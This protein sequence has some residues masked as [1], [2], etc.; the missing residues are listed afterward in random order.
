MSYAL[1][2]PHRIRWGFSAGASTAM[3]ALLVAAAAVLPATGLQHANTAPT[4]AAATEGGISPALTKLADRHP[5]KRIEAIVQ[6]RK[7]VGPAEARRVSRAHD[8]RVIGD[9]HVING[10]ALRMSAGDA[11]S[12]AKDERVRAISLN[13]RV[14]ENG[15]GR[16]QRRSLDAGVLSSLLATSYNRSIQATDAWAA[17]GTGD[18]IGVAVVDTGIAAGHADFLTAPRSSSRVV[19]S[20][21][22]NPYAKNDGDRYGHGTH[23]AGIA[24]GNSLNRSA[25]DPHYGEY[26]GTAPEADLINVKIADE[27][28]NATV[29][30]AIYG[31]QFVID[32]KADYNIRV[33]NL[34]FESAAADSYKIDPL[35]AAAEAAWFSGIVVVAA[36]G[37]RGTASDAVHHAPGNDPY[38]I[39]VGASDDKGTATIGDDVVASWSSRGKT[40]DGFAKPD[41]V[42]PGTRIVSTLAQN[43]E[44]ASMCPTCITGDEYIRA[45]GTSMSAPMVAGGVADLLQVHPS[46]TPN[47]VKGVI[48][49]TRRA[50]SGG[51]LLSLKAAITQSGNDAT[52]NKGLT[53]STL[54]DPTSG[55]VDY[56]KSRWSKSRWSRSS[57]SRS[58]WSRSSWS[59]DC[60]KLANGSIDP[61]RSSWSRS[62]WSTRL[63]R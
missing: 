19:A 3:L 7:G 55:E 30:D 5:A 18:N 20:A 22:T 35:D 56:T 40:Q 51:Q 6:Y 12:L 8:A 17:G 42:A 34:S 27:S 31:L 11:V 28:G 62:S 57:W 46:W 54:I 32:K 2:L 24:A 52:A 37:N 25:K 10:L 59:C 16:H 13:H 47:Q 1:A 26:A 38:V 15:F 23:V 44:F 48:L 60:S 39:T 36:A 45:S 49:G 4:A 50:I 33:V 41:V 53:P 14:R 63:G 21:A 58:S 43:S 29:L 9:L 61:T